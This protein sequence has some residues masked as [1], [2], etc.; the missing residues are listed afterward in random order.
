MRTTRKSRRRN[1]AF[2]GDGLYRAVRP[3]ARAFRHRALASADSRALPAALNFLLGRGAGFADAV[4][5]LILAHLALAPAAIL[6][7]ATALILRFRFIGAPS[8][9]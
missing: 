9:G 8:A 5:P 1:R 2:F 3:A 7:R 4:V 6:A